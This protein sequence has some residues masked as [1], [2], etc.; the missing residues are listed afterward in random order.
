MHLMAGEGNQTL[1]NG[2]EWRSVSQKDLQSD[3][4]IKKVE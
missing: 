3:F 1:L 4:Y 2:E